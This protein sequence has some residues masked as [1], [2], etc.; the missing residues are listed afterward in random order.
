[1]IIFNI[2]RTE[3]LEETDSY[4]RFK[5]DEKALYDINLKVYIIHFIDTDEYYE[6][7]NTASGFSMINNNLIYENTAH[8]LH[9]VIF[10][11]MQILEEE[12]K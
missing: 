12:K 6:V 1:M 2:Q 4:I 9:F 11:S 7:V 8:F 5:H 10:N 3:L